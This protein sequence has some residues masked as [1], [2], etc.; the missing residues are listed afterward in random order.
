MEVKYIVAVEYTEGSP[1][2]RTFDD[3]LEAEWFIH[4]LRNDVLATKIHMRRVK[5]QTGDD[6]KERLAESE[7]MKLWSRLNDGWVCEYP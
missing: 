2:T 1:Y 5:V 4:R 6:G 7:I 3:L